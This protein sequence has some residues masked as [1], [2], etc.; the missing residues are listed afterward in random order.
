MFVVT[1]QAIEYLM[2]VCTHV[3][4][5]LRMLLHVLIISLCFSSDVQKHLLYVFSFFSNN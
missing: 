2:Y 1:I 5:N 4:I 3:Y